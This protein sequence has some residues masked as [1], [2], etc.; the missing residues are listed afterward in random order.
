MTFATPAMS[1]FVRPSTP[2]VEECCLPSEVSVAPDAEARRIASS[3]G[4][5]DEA[6][7]RQ[8]YDLYHG[9]LLRLAI[10]LARGDEALA[11]D[12]TQAVFV[13]AAQKLR[14]AESEKHLWNWLA[15]VTRQHIGKAWR[16]RGK[17]S[18]LVGVENLPEVADQ[19]RAD[20]ILEVTL[21]AAM[22]W[23]DADEQQLLEAFY[24]DH[25]SCKEI[26]EQLNVTPK[27]VSSRLERVRDKL[28][29]LVAKSLGHES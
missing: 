16:Q 24:F 8:L 18:P 12:V 17:N 2:R 29:S 27:A 14:G 15:R 4:R 25:L 9:R 7:F 1:M 28:R 26:A 19:D 22:S 20:S 21:D 23:M 11:Q 6:A 10:V 3:V 13:T 5:G